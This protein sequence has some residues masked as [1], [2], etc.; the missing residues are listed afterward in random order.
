MVCRP[1]SQLVEPFETA[2]AVADILE[3]VLM[4]RVADPSKH[5]VDEQVVAN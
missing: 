1:W 2:M 4:L 3:S 5:I